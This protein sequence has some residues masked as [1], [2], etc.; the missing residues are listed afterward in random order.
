MKKSVLNLRGVQALSQ[1]E[2]KAVQGGWI[3]DL[4]NLCGAY[5]F[6]SVESQCL[7]LTEYYP[8]WDKNTRKCSVIG[9]NC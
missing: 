7:S 4:S 3:P 2:Q 8:I 1:K 9:N 5:T 6:N